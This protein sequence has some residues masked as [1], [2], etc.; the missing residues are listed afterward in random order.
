MANYKYISIP[1][2]R[3]AVEWLTDNGFS[4][5]HDIGTFICY[6]AT[7]EVYDHYGSVEDVEVEFICNTQEEF[8]QKVNESK[9]MGML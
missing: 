4:P 2:S 5:Q 3:L 8:I 6:H 7:S 1:T 9:L